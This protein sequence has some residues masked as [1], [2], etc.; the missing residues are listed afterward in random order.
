MARVSL[1]YRH[2][3]IRQSRQSITVALQTFQRDG[4]SSVCA[5]KYNYKYEDITVE[6]GT[7]TSTE[8]YCRAGIASWSPL[9]FMLVRVHSVK[10]GHP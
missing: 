8:Y 9:T 2:A 7:W 6:Q 3:E 10:L 1:A 5:F 4:T